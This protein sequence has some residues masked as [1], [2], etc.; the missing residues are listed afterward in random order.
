MLVGPG[1]VLWGDVELGR[2]D[3]LWETD[4]GRAAW[5]LGSTW[6]A[7]L[8]EAGVGGASVHRG[9]VVRTAWSQIVCFAGTGPGEVVV[10]G[11][12]CVGISQRRTRESCRFQFAVMLRWEPHRLLEVLALD[13]AARER[14]ERDLSGVASPVRADPATLARAFERHLP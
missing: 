5:W 8:A 4:V 6:A 9:P 3:P 2:A 13:G 7:A 11:R 12:K 14:A 1:E 10:G